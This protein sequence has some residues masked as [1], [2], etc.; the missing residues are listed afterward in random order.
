V[1]GAGHIEP[2]RARAR[3]LARD[4]LQGVERIDRAGQHELARRVVVGHDEAEPVRERAH[5]A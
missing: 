2:A 1:E 5:V 3:L 4:L